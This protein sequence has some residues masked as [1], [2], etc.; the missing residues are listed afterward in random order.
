MKEEDKTKEQLIN[1]SAK[2]RQRIAELER[3]KN[4]HKQTEE[5][6]QESEERYR[7]L[8][9]S[10][11]DIIF[12][13]TLDGIITSLNPAFEIITGWPRDECLGRNFKTIL[14]S[15]VT[16]DEASF[17]MELHQR[18]LKGEPFPQSLELRI[19]S[20]S[21]EYITIEIS[22]MQQTRNGEVVGGLGIARDITERRR[23]E[24]HVKEQAALLKK[25][26][27]ERRHAEERLQERA[28]LLD[29]AHD[30]IIVWDLEN[31]ITYWNEGAQRL[32]GWTAEEAAGKNV[33]E[34]L[35]KEESSELITAQKSIIERGEWRGELK[36]LVKDGT[37]I[38]VESRWTLIRSRRGRLKTILTIN[39]DI[40]EKKKLEAQ[41]LRV[42]RLESIGTLAGGMA[43][44]LNNMLTPI[45]LSLQLLK[46]K[47]TDEQDQK[48]LDILERNSRRG[49][50][51]IK[52]VL[53]FAKGVEGERNSIQMAH[54]ISEIK[55]IIKET[56]PRTIEIQ[57]DVQKDLWMVCGDATQLHQVL[58]NLFVN[59]RDAMPYGGTLSIS[60]EN[61]FIDELYAQKNIEAKVGPYI[62]ISISD[63][64]AGIPPE[65]MDRIFEPF[66]TTKEAGKG[67]GLG[68]STALGIVKSHGGFINMYSEVGKCTKFNV[69]LPVIKM[70]AQKEE[71]QKPEIPSGH[72]EFI[73]VAEDEDSIRE[74]TRTTL[75]KYG[76]RVLTACDGAEAVASY[77]QNKEEIDLVLMDM[78]MPFMD[79]LASVQA[80]RRI[81]PQ[82]KII[83]VSGLAE[84]DKIAK[85]VDSHVHAFLSKPYTTGELL[86]TINEVLNAKK[87]DE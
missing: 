42:Q 16:P 62:I 37:E 14:R 54:I 58:M 66:F 73:L 71:M 29:K 26:I 85:I 39:T 49:A 18:I 47:F 9:E 5:K 60:A 32:Y 25:E 33:N 38:I 21:G 84:K 44:D 1:E 31:G 10:A 69:Y 2:P 81:E 22:L 77:V 83:V 78:M 20:K 87:K 76:Y 7:N 41:F 36:Q 64:G 15:L 52:Q 82:V 74:T 56:F 53:S 3:V 43:H 51:L 68:L 75:E 50:D 79:G 12:T 48:L 86:K 70:E 34:L 63:T 61:F 27:I 40:T 23:T 55:K 6:L 46:E 11:R 80:L 13:F 72:G 57:T 19:L 35:N 8:I 30:A 65:I 24:E 17:L 59:A 28:A 67:T 45:M 4:Q